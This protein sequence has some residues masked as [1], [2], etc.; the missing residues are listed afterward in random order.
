[1]K[2]KYLLIAILFS[3]FAANAQS[4]D[5]INEKKNELKVNVLVPFNGALQGTYERNLNKKSSVG[6]SLFTVFDNDKGEKDLNYS[7]SPYYR[8]YFGKKYASGFFAEGFGMLSSI[9]G[10]KIYDVN[11][12]SIFTEGSDVID[13]SLGIGLGSK[14]VTKSGIIFEINAGWGKLLFNADKTDH[15]QVARFGFHLGYRF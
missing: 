9:D 11:D 4:D 13:L 3:V 8:R 7:V 14:W 2:K 1:M 10:K 6:V 15:N 5:P 12:K